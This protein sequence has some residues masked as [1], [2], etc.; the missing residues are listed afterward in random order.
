[1]PVTS[2]CTSRGLPKLSTLS[3]GGLGIPEVLSIRR[4]VQARS[5]QPWHS[6]S[7]DLN[8][9]ISIG[10]GTS[11]GVFCCAVSDSQAFA[12]YT[13]VKAVVVRV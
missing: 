1:M 9:S 5:A 8:Y 7:S 10:K 6:N 12:K 11:N 13:G 4:G 3:S 2:Q